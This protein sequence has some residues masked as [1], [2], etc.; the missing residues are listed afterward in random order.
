MTSRGLLLTAVATA[1]LIGVTW[2]AWYWLSTPIPPEFP[3]EQM[4]QAVAETIAKALA[5]VR[6]Q[7]RSG[8]AW[9]QLALAAAANGYGDQALVCFEQAA[10]LDAT[11][12]RWPYLHGNLLQDGR[13]QDPLPLWRQA[14]ERSRSADQRG[15]VLF[16]LVLGLIETAQGD[17]AERH[18][19]ALEDLEGASDRVHLGRGLL[20]MAS[21]DTAAARQHLAAAL[22][23]P[24]ARKLA[25]AN[26]ATIAIADGD[27]ALARYYQQ[28]AARLPADL[29]WPDLFVDEMNRLAVNR[30]ARMSDAASL[31]NAGRLPEA[32]AVLRQVIATTPD[33]SAYLS[34]GIALT[35]LHRFD[36]A[37]DALN[38][39]LLL[40]PQQMHAHH[41]LATIRFVQAEKL[42]TEPGGSARAQDLFRAVVAA[43]DKALAIKPFDPFAHLTRGSA[44]RHLGRTDEALQ[45]LRAAVSCRPGLAD[46]HLA[47]GEALAE[48]G[49][50]AFRSDGAS[51]PRAC[52]RP[53]A[54]IAMASPALIF[55]MSLPPKG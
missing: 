44:L 35:K 48:A 21:D 8:D 24:H 9:G 22:G 20:A 31:E 43:E 5:E 25:T 29:P 15:T 23:S 1:G 16:R 53:T 38:T 54:R 37:E 46:T 10:Q 55:F 19:H 14:L 12:P 11:N 26:L 2:F 36:E 52:D 7:P 49:Q 50:L 51:W 13:T 4:E 47:L 28:G 39:A 17:E 30:V 27:S 40:D 45:S 41:F 32:V 18:L 3:V 42:L 6:R 34:L 33:A